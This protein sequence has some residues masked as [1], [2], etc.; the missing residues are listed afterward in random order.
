MSANVDAVRGGYEAL[1]R[2][3]VPTILAALDDNV[4]WTEAEGFPYAGTYVGPQAVLDNVLMRLATEWDGF[5]AVPTDF[6]DG[7]DRVVAMGRYGGVFKE[8]GK[9]LDCD[10]AHIW[11]L[12]NGKVVGFKQYVDSALVRDVIT[13]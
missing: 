8:T 7:G 1:A 11:T 3:D 9:S 10:F 4:Q 6:I 2:G 5:S 12:D 13:P